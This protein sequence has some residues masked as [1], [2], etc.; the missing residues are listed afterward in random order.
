M[1]VFSDR[2]ATLEG[3]RRKRDEGLVTPYILFSNYILATT[4]TAYI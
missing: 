2:V 3:G 1:V 4:H